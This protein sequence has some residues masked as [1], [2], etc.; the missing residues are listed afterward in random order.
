MLRTRILTAFVLGS[1]VL[2]AIFLLPAL[3]A[4]AVL[5][6]LWILGGWEW[7]AFA[8]LGSGGRVIYAGLVAV[9]VVSAPWWV[10]R[11][12]VLEGLLATATVWW[13]LAFAALLGGYRRI[14]ASIVAVAGLLVLL[15]S[16]AMLAYLLSVP[17]HGAALT[18]TALLLVWAADI[19]AFFF[20]R[21][22]GRVKL[23]PVVSPGK[24]WEGVAGGAGTALVAG[25]LAAA[26]LPVGWTLHAAIAVL[27][28]LISV[29]G[30]LTV[31]LGKRNVGLKD[32]GALLPGHGGVLDRIDSLTAALPA[33]VLLL[34]LAEVL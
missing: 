9:A 19:G 5:G 18:F 3:W 20:G 24:T 13:L 10:G 17:G 12:P 14:P 28:A 16:W 29:V 31:S 30:D 2:G 4:A 33:Y 21:R 11:E 22:L 32:S 27:T 25:A 6:V 7:G 34:H 8:R 23:A 15:P 26:W 1:L